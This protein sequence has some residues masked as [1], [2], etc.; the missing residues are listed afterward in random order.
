[1]WSHLAQQ[2][3][4]ELIEQWEDAKRHLRDKN[5]S[6]EDENKLVATIVWTSYSLVSMG[7][8]LLDKQWVNPSEAN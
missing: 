2:N 8:K 1:M 7:Y 5:F 3:A 6:P 4:S